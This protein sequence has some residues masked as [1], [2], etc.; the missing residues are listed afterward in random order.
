MNLP[1]VGLITFG[2][3]REHEWNAVFKKMAEP[4]HQQ[5]IAFFQTLPIMVH[6]NQ[7]VARHKGD[8]D[9]QVD[10]LKAAGIEALVVHTPCWRSPD[11]VVRGVQRAGLPTVVVTNKSPSTHGTVGF[12]GAAGT[13]DQIGFPH[14]RVRADF[15]GPDASTIAD[16]AMPYFRAASAQAPCAARPSVCLAGVRWASTPAPSTP[17]SGSDS[18]RSIPN[19]STSLR[20]SAGPTWWM[21]QKQRQWSLVG[22]KHRPGGL[23]QG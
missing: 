11:L 13:L 7:S 19:T 3:N 18:S 8:I 23:R 12:L 20:L 16:K 4:R 1:K 5:A 14:L 17:C 2:D 21:M 6:A 15:D 10:A 22:E 9:A